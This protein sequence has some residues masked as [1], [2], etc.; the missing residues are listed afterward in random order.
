VR[1]AERTHRLIQAGADPR[2]LGLGDPGVDAQS[3]DQV[4]DRTGGDPVHVGLHD[5]RV[6]GLIDPPAWF[7]DHRE[8]RALT[9][10]RD[11]QRHI[12]GLG[13][14]L[15]VPVTVALGRARRRAFVAGRADHL[16]RLGLDQ[17]LQHHPNR[18]PD[19]IH[20]LPGPERL[21]QL[22]HGRRGQGRLG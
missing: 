3:G 15:P 18:L 21:Q 5:H 9:Q 13:G 14:Q 12:P 1:V 22:G 8:E 20:A 2:H 16:G 17:L 19:Q 7:Q 10:L 4:I 11:P 6:Q